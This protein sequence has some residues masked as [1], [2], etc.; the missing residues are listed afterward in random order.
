M[1]TCENVAELARVLAGKT[2]M[3]LQVAGETRSDRAR[4]ETARPS[5]HAAAYRKENQWLNTKADC[6][7]RLTATVFS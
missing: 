4:D 5:A 6:A 2:K 3:P 7:K 1:R